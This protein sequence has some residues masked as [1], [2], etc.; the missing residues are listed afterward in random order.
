MV[1][2]FKVFMAICLAW[3][4]ALIILFLAIWALEACSWRTIAASLASFSSSAASAAYFWACSN[5]L[6][7]SSVCSKS[8]T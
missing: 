1:M 5:N 8:S 4:S 2:V 6:A 3:F 7:S